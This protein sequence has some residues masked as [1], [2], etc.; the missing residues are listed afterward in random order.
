MALQKTN[1]AG[2]MK[3]PKTGLVLNTN[4]KELVKFKAERQRAKD[5]VDLKAR[6]A[7][8]EAKIVRLEALVHDLI[9]WKLSHVVYV[10][11]RQARVAGPKE[12][13]KV[14]HVFETAKSVKVI[15]LNG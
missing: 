10:P 7:Q 2:Y 14:R 12:L 6:V 4:D 9:G 5:V 8:L 11:P 1:A 3:D 15:A 13:K